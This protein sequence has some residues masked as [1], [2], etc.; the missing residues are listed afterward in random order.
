MI[1]I[2]LL[3][4]KKQQEKESSKR[5]LILFFLIIIA[6]CF[7][8]WIPYAS[9]QSK[10][11]KIVGENSQ[12]QQEIESLK[13]QVKDV[14][15]LTGE[16]NNLTEQLNVLSSLESGRAGPVRVMD[17]VQLILST[18]RNELERVLQKKLKGLRAS[19]KK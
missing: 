8:L 18:P 1:R 7:L 9:E 14:E 3:P 10:R 2:N 15:R 6:E 13:T 11:E 16:K 5:L 12:K 19:A 17:E 4:I